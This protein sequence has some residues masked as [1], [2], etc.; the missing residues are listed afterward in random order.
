LKEGFPSIVPVV[1]FAKAQH[2]SV[3]FFLAKTTSQAKKQPFS[4]N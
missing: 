4:Q 3:A 1:K 2:F